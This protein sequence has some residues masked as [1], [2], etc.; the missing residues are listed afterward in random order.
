V[1]LN[2][3]PFLLAELSSMELRA[4]Y[5]VEGALTGRHKSRLQSHAVEFV[6]HRAYTPSDDWRRIDWRVFARTDRWV[7][8]EQEAETNLRAVLLLDVSKSMSFG[9]NP[10][11]KIRYASILAASL[12]YLLVHQGESVGLGFFNAG[13]KNFI[14]ARGGAAHLSYL[15]DVLDKIEPEGETDLAASLEQVGQRLPRRSL[16][17]VLSDFLLE[18]EKILAAAKTLVSRR[19]EVALLQVLDR[20][21]I[22]FN[23]DGEFILRDMESGSDLRVSAAEIRDDY[24]RLMRERL[25]QTRRALASQGIDY[26]LFDTSVPLDAALSRFLQA[27]RARELSAAVG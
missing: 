1:S 14:P 19:H 2:L 8:R 10:F 16:V 3:D 12:S 20:D 24:R 15:S 11:P 23:I 18:P 22:D 26:A 7:V 17:L 21:E 6:G 4:R 13:L 27:R 9:K 5:V 25:D